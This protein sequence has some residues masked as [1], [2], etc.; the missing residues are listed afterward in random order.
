MG[1]GNDMS[2]AFQI[3][4]LMTRKGRQS[5]C[6]EGSTLNGVTAVS[7]SKMGN[8]ITREFQLFVYNGNQKC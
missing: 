7:S 1:G 2:L 5:I 3:K 8:K 4:D 6:I